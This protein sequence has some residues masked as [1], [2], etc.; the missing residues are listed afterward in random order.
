ML[1][2][3]GLG[4][5][6]LQDGEPLGVARRPTFVERVQEMVETVEK[7][8]AEPAPEGSRKAK[9]NNDCRQL[10]SRSP[11][12]KDLIAG[13][14]KVLFVGCGT[15]VTVCLAGG[16]REVGIMSSAMRMARKARRA[17]AWR[18]SQMTIERQCENEFIEDLAEPAAE[19]RR[20]PLVRLRR[21]RAG[22][23]RA[24]PR[25]AGLRRL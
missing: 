1:D 19:R 17:A 5:E 4:G 12:L 6:R 23:R 9:V 18:S 11:R 25:Q 16:E 8:W 21:R 14:E 10:E 7:L 13:H 24:L 2:E 22:H 3:I 20:H 15:C